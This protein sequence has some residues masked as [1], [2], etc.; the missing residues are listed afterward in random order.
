MHIVS[1]IIKLV[2]S[3]KATMLKSVKTQRTIH[4][5]RWVK[6]SRDNYDSFV[7]FV[8]YPLFLGDDTRAGPRGLEKL[9]ISRKLKSSLGGGARLFLLGV[10]PRPSPPP[11]LTRGTAEILNESLLMKATFRALPP[12]RFPGRRRT[13]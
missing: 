3:D 4:F 2:E 13:R 9:I 6:P 11:P 7:P 8:P 10:V 1:S 5:I 12:R